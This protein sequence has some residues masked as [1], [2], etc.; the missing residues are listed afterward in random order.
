MSPPIIACGPH[1]P[2]EEALAKPSLVVTIHLSRVRAEALLALL[3]LHPQRQWEPQRKAVR[4]A[5]E[6]KHA[7]GE[8][9]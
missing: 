1:Q 9:P 7:T 2:E 8:Q 3:E 4:R 5:L 6:R